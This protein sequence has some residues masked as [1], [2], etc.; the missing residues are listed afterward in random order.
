MSEQ[1]IYFRPPSEMNSFLIR[2]MHGCPHNQ[3]TFCNLFK[4][5]Q[6]HPIPV[7]QVFQGID[8][9]VEDL[10][11]LAPYVKS[12]YLEGGDPLA[13]CSDDLL[14]IMEH[15]KS[16]FASLNRFACYATARF[17]CR[18]KQEELNALGQAGLRRVFVGLESGYDPILEKTRKGCTKADLIHAG[19]MLAQAGI[20]MDV[21]MMLGIGGQEYSRQHILETADVINVISPVCVRVRTFTPKSGTN[22]GKDFQEGRFVL[23]TPHNLLIELRLLAET[24]T[25]P[26]QLLSEHW[27][28]HLLF[29]ACLPESKDK[30]LQYIDNALGQPETF[31]R[32]L[33]ITDRRS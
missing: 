26:L 27:T 7:E 10:A 32:P 4:K 29:N 19:E 15:A 13:L 22:L 20:E 3:C 33:N 14:R 18:K 11:D 23:M 31:F 28:D 12:I 5:V 17:L 8:Q 2:V 6:F 24:I 1:E 30:L 16:R 21:S 25:S 9:D